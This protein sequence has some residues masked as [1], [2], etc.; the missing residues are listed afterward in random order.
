M[1]HA[2][3]IN[4]SQVEHLLIHRNI[5]YVCN[6]SKKRYHLYIY[7]YNMFIIMRKAYKRRLISEDDDCSR[8]VE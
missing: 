3:A 1:T 2:G 7:N 5:S 8:K 4:H 6:E